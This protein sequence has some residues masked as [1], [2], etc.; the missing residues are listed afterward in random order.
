MAKWTKSTLLDRFGD[1]LVELGY[2]NEKDEL[3]DDTAESEV[4]STI[5]LSEVLERVK[6]DIVR[7]SMTRRV[8]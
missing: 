5:P 1:E 6:G 3:Y 2:I 8:R 4:L 7:E